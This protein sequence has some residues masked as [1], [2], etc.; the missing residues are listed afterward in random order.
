MAYRTYDALFSA[1]LTSYQNASSDPARKPVVGDELYMRAAGLASALWGLYREA[2]WVKAQALPTTADG[3][4][5]ELHA[6]EHGLTKGA[7]ESY[8][9]LLERLLNR[10]RNPPAGGNKT[11]YENWAMEVEVAGE[12]ADTVRCYPAGLGPGTC[13]LVVSRAS[14]TPSQAL[15]DQIRAVCLDR[16]PVVPAEVYVWAP[17]FRDL[18]LSI[19]APGADRAIAEGKIRAY[20]AELLPGQ[21]LYAD[22]LKAYCYLA[23]ATSVSLALP[24]QVPGK[25]EQIRLRSLAW[26]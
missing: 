9:A 26:L 16:G 5:L 19:A 22:V 23:G 20:I 12:R 14:A 1:I 8:G 15:L 7:G 4:E 3:P 10:L 21:A 2:A 13:V 18:D 25:F 11:D 17:S 6:Q 24:N